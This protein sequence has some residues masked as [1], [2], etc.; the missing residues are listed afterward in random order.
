[1]C[2]KKSNYLKHHFD[3][4][5]SIKIIKPTAYF[6]DPLPYRTISTAVRPRKCYLGCALLMVMCQAYDGLCKVQHRAFRRWCGPEPRTNKI[7]LKV[8]WRLYY[9]LFCRTWIYHFSFPR[10]LVTCRQPFGKNTISFNQQC[11]FF[12]CHL[13]SFDSQGKLDSEYVRPWEASSSASC[14]VPWPMSVLG[15][16]NMDY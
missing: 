5:M 16:E 1:M 9:R 3:K 4:K 13:C 14:N 12:C 10:V 11:F 2:H 8:L 6:F 7:L 15:P